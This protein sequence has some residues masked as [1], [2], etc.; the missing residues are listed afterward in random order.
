MCP[1]LFTYH[2]P[3]KFY[4]ILYISMYIQKIYVYYIN[5]TCIILFNVKV[6]IEFDF[7]I[8]YLQGRLLN[9]KN[10]SHYPDYL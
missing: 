7:F 1:I 10:N 4:K 5:K 6:K 3:I 9:N 2:V 8:E